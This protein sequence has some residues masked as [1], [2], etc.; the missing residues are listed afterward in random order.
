MKESINVTYTCDDKYFDYLEVS[1]ESMLDS[2]NTTSQY[3]IDF[4]I[5]QINFSDKQK[6]KLTSLIEKKDLNNRIF[7]Y[8]YKLSNKFNLS[9][10]KPIEIVTL[11]YYLPIFFP[12]INKAIFVDSDTLFCADIKELWETNLDN[13]WIATT[14]CIL[15]KDSLDSYNTTTH[16]YFWSPEQTMNAGIAILDFEKMKELNV[17][18]ILEE[19]TEEHQ[20]L[21]SLPEQ[22]AISFNFPVRKLIEHKWNWRGCLA[23]S[24]PFWSIKKIDRI[25]QE[26]LQIKPSMIHFQAPFRPNTHIINSRYFELWTKYYKKIHSKPI[27]VKKLNF[28][29]FHYLSSEKKNRILSYLG[30]LELRRNPTL[31]IK[32]I[33]YILF[34]I[35]SIILNAIKYVQYYRNPHSYKFPYILPKEV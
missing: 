12:T 32:A 28:L 5:V 19:W 23:A 14:P 22:E 31:F 21:L 15:S 3:N 10:Y 9:P 18:K 26:Y 1:I 20:N 6:E 25:T 35:P 17:T 27:E 29:E 24:E 16:G 7:Y 2:F 34:D 13:H 11:I 4:Y 8:D 33:Y 30:I